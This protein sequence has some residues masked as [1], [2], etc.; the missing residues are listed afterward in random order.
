MGLQHVGCTPPQRFRGGSTGPSLPGDQPP[1]PPWA[2][3]PPRARF[4]V[5]VLAKDGLR[6]TAPA[7]LPP[8]VPALPPAA[9]PWPSLWHSL[10]RG[11]F[12]FVEPLSWSPSGS[13]RVSAQVSS[14][15]PSLPSAVL[16]APCLSRWVHA[17]SSAL[18]PS[19]LGPQVQPLVPARPLTSILLLS[20][21][22]PT[23]SPDSARELRPGVPWLHFSRQS[24]RS[25][26]H[27]D[28]ESQSPG[29]VRSRRSTATAQHP[30]RG[31][32]EGPGSCMWHG[33]PWVSC[34]L[35]HL[36]PEILYNLVCSAHGPMALSSGSC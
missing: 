7:L 10:S 20:R 1:P 25:S 31:G 26:S 23:C 9:S 36:A 6:P 11:P 14:G 30:P 13:W 12:L 29:P 22:V 33:I 24:G 19:V 21:T 2:P 3:L 15:H 18:L 8:S 5:Q 28:P 32:G 27:V 34:P 17:A 4:P 35:N 16:L